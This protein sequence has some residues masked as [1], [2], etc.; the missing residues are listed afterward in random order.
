LLDAS[1]KIISASASIIEKTLPEIYFDWNS[2]KQISELDL[3]NLI[4]LDDIK[5]VQ[6]I[7]T[8]ANMHITEI[9]SLNLT[10]E[11]IISHCNSVSNS[12]N[13]SF[14]L[15]SDSVTP[16]LSE[17]LLDLMKK[18]GSTIYDLGTYL[19]WW[20]FEINKNLEDIEI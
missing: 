17:Q 10:N 3:T 5:A 18:L 8:R 6:T 7:I 20:E 19:I 16:L 2:I 1:T 11:P 12:V 15:I 14:I 4:A 9:G 13:E